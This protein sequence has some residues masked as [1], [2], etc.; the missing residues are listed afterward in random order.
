MKHRDL[1]HTHA[2]QENSSAVFVL[3]YFLFW[4]AGGGSFCFLL[5]ADRP[6]GDD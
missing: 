6:R 1:Y 3:F 5:P 4:G 2:A